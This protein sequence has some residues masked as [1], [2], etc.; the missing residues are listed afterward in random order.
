M[1]ANGIPDLGNIGRERQQKMRL[2]PDDVRM[3]NDVGIG[4]DSAGNVELT[5]LYTFNPPGM[6]PVVKQFVV[7][8]PAEVYYGRLVAH[9]GPVLAAS[10][11]EAARMATALAPFAA[12]TGKETVEKAEAAAAA[13]A[14]QRRKAAGDG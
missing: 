1:S 2:P 8:V 6:T 11:E 7:V 10:A 13:L 9:A 12:K 4:V 5:F 3:A 14:E